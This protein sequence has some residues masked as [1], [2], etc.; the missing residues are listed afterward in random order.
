MMVFKR[1]A[2]ALA[3]GM[4]IVGANAAT[5]VQTGAAATLH[6]VSSAAASLKAVASGTVINTVAATVGARTLQLGDKINITVSGA[7]FDR[8]ALAAVPVTLN[9]SAVA[10]W[11]L[12][13][14][15]DTMLIGTV[16]TISGTDNTANVMTLTGAYDLT[17]V[18]TGTSVTIA[19][20]VSRLVLGVDSVVH[21]ILSPATNFVELTTTPSLQLYALGAKITDTATVASSFVNLDA[22]SANATATSVTVPVATLTATVLNDSNAAAATGT[23]LLKL[24]GVP[25][26]V[27]S[28][29]YA[30]AGVSQ[31]DAT[32]L[33]APTT[34]TPG[35]GQF[36]LD[37]AGNGFA[38]VTAAAS[39]AVIAATAM[40]FTYSG[41][42]A[43]IPTTVNLQ[44]DYL[45]GA[46]DP[47]IAH[48]TLAASPIS[49]IVRN[50]S[51]FSVNSM[52]ALNKLKITDLSGA[53]TASTGSISATAYD[54]AGVVVSGSP[55]ITALTSNSTTVINGADI[56]AA[57]PGAVR[58]DFV[59][60]STE[61][62]VSNVK[63]TADGTTA[64]NYR[65]STD[66]AGVV[67]GN[68][69]L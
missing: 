6:A 29:A 63:K 5:N 55:T 19:T 31:S 18:A 3:L 15:T 26:T 69:T 58:F 42:A 21:A 38:K 10:S 37:G 8:A 16:T 14:A 2:I 24:T 32:G 47:F 51:A 12:D 66:G 27:T 65:N 40:T 35:G 50:G 62:A 60:E 49:T 46:A 9:D 28:I 44:A 25:S 59:V 1:T 34:A 7:K 53:L 20:T 23:L 67:A 39:K 57:Y 4:T 43:I 11:T 68:G 52:G 13:A 54:A 64:T 17:G 22:T 45:A 48:T 41:L 30:A 33:A 36:W 61:I 56:V